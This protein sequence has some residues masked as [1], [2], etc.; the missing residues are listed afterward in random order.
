MARTFGFLMSEKGEVNDVAILKDSSE[1][2]WNQM[3]RLHQF[4]P[5]TQGLSRKA[6][7][8]S[9]TDLVDTGD[10]SHR[11]GIGGTK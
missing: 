4:N 3:R 11:S 9:L 7:E 5:M 6:L 10:T 2:I 8:M 1:L